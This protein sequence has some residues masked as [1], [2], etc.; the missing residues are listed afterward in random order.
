MWLY[1]SANYL[2]ETVSDNASNYS[3][4]VRAAGS[5][6]VSWFQLPQLHAFGFLLFFSGVLVGP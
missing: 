6:S 5:R 3:L 4:F 1:Q 2:P